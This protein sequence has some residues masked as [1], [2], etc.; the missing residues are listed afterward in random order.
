MHIISFLQVCL[1]NLVTAQSHRKR[2]AVK[3]TKSLETVTILVQHE[4]VLISCR[5]VD[6]FVHNTVTRR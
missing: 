4:N 2:C 5:T 3:T 6:Q 1:V